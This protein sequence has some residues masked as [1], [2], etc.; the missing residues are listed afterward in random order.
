MSQ[1][2]DAVNALEIEKKSLE[3]NVLMST[4]KVASLDR[5]ITDYEKCSAI[6]NYVVQTGCDE[7]IENFE[8]VISG[9]LKDI[10][11]E[12][13]EFKFNL[14]KRAKT[15]ACEFVLHTDEY[16]GFIDLTM[17][18]GR[19]VKEVIGIILR[20]LI[21]NLDKDM[22]RFLILDEPFGGLEPERQV[23]ARDFMKNVA[24]EFGIQL[25]VVTQSR[26]FNEAA[27]KELIIEN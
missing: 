17:T 3:R 7:I 13:Y 1:L 5:K 25:L 4:T 12:S 21:I 10:F 9:G 15:T 20:L 26:E 16:P 14:A 27:D 24:A 19:S 18:H 8:G 2:G 6:F 22:N 11:D 23:I